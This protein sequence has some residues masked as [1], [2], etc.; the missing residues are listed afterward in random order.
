VERPA[1]RAQVSMERPAGG[2]SIKADDLAPIVDSMGSRVDRT[3][4]VDGRE[5]WSGRP[6]WE[7]CRPRC[8][9]QYRYSELGQDR[10]PGACV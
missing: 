6:G 10:F 7:P 5:A 9:Q 3:W 2:G 4:D 1:G 8:R